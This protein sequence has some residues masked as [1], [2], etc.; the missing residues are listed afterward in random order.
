MRNSIQPTAC[1]PSPQGLYHPAW[2]HDACG[3]G[4]LC[5]LKGE[6]SHDLVS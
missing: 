1:Y 4:M 3:V 2:E 5:S 6:K